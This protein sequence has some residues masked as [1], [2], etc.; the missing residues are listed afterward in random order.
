MPLLDILLK[1]AKAEAP[2][3]VVIK[4]NPKYI[5]G[6]PQADAFYE[7]L[8]QELTDA[9]YQTDFDP[10]EPF[11]EPPAA[12]LWVG[13]SRGIDRLR[14]APPG[15]RVLGIGGA[16]HGKIPVV[17]HP[18]DV[19]PHIPSELFAEGIDHDAAIAKLGLNPDDFDKGSHYELT[20]EM[21]KA[22]RTLAAANE[23]KAGLPPSVP[24][25]RRAMTEAGLPRDVRFYVN[26]NRATAF[27]GDWHE[28]DVC[29]KACALGK[30]LFDEWEDPDD[31]EI[32]MPDW[33]KH[34]VASETKRLDTS[35][36]SV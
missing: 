29:G 23:K 33:A 27:L 24:E 13:H 35:D 19:S 4:G 20:D 16:G 18:R 11:T 9:G 22:L 3:A 30:K 17:N 31:T 21:R 12:D 10:G 7:A 6:N 15:T 28:D 26:G 36:A 5:E 2:R 25:I 32:G 8:R 14:F 34:D 1:S